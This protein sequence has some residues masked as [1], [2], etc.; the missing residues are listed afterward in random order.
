MRSR[1]SGRKTMTLSSRLTNSGRKLCETA[2]STCSC[3]N[4]SPRRRKAESGALVRGGA[5]IGREDD[6]GMTEVGDLPHRVSE[7]A[8][9]EDLQEQ[10]PDIGVRLLE[11]IE[12]DHRER[13]LADALDQRLGHR[14]VVAT[15]R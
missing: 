8:V 6:D 11:L 2:R 12:Q 7:A 9:V 4:A 10:I 5:E 3:E 14:L 15:R 13:L 1:V